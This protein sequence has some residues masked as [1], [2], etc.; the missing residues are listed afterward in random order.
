MSVLSDTTAE[1]R[2]LSIVAEEGRI[3]GPP[4]ARALLEA[5]GLQTD[6]FSDARA[7]LVFGVFADAL[8]KGRH[9]IRET[10]WPELQR[11]A[12]DAKWEDFARFFVPASVGTSE[13]ARGLGLAL[14]NLASRRRAYE[15]AKRII[16]LA[17]TGEAV[18][19]ELA[20]EMHEAANSIPGRSGAWATARRGVEAA[21]KRIRLVQDGRLLP[22]VPTGYHEIDRLVGGLQPT[23]VAIIGQQ[24]VVKSGF[25]LSILRNMARAGRKGALLCPEDRQDWLGFR[26]LAHHSGV[27]QFIL[28]NKPLAESQWQDVASADAQVSEFDSRILVDDRPH[29]RPGEVITAAREAY[30]ER[31]AEAVFVDNLSAIRFAR[32][33]RRDLDVQEFIENGRALADEFKAPFAVVCHTDIKTA[34]PTDIPALW[35]CREA[36]N[37]IA[38]VCRQ[39]FGIALGVAPK[40]G[41]APLDIQ[42]GILKTQIGKPG[43]AVSLPFRARSGMLEDQRPEESEQGAFL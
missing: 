23:F 14:K 8:A 10:L 36:P 7:R 29:L 5:C 22:N 26:L 4:R 35:Q 32:G 13:E 9:P 27:P 30:S 25:V 28:R 18:G 11:S 33:D 40:D 34:K 21:A 19:D 20:Q 16:A 31:G 1:A 17:E 37:A 15:A 43:L 12:R 41:A 6:D 2:L 24:G 39:A 42:V 3:I 38:L